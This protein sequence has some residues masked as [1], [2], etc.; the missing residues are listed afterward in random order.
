MRIPKETL[1]CFTYKEDLHIASDLELIWH[2][3]LREFRPK[4]IKVVCVNRVHLSLCASMP[5]SMSHV[6]HVALIAT[7]CMSLITS[8]KPPLDMD[9]AMVSAPSCFS[10]CVWS[11]RVCIHFRP[12]GWWDSPDYIILFTLIFPG[13][14][15]RLPPT[16]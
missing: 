6:I 9:T 13:G 7:S 2:Y 14:D 16:S 12:W 15:K 11:R 4:Q 5:V 10:L 3:P 1:K 8:F